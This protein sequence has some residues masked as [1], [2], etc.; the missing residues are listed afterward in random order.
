MLIGSYLVDSVILRMDK[1]SNAFQEPDAPED[2]TIRAFV[3]YGEY[4]IQ[5][6]EGQVIVS[7]T[8]VRMRPRTII[9]SGYATMAAN[10]ISEKDLIV[11]DGAEHAIMKIAKPRDFTVRGLDVY[12]T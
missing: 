2:E 8:K 4:R 9:T 3:E 10:T 7:N 12:V 11:F 1:G 6:A 5:N